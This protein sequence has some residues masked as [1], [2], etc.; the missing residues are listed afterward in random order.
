ML[1]LLF[2]LI[3]V[4]YIILC[5]CCRFCLKVYFIWYGYYY[6]FFLIICMK[7][8]FPS[9]LFQ[10]MC[11][12]SSEVIMIGMY[13]LWFCY[14]SSGCFVYFLYSFLPLVPFLVLWWVS[15]VECL[16]F[17]SFFFLRATAA[18]YGSSQAR[19]WIGAAVVGLCHSNASS[20]PHL[21]PVP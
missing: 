2:V 16:C 8:L 5:F 19:D 20:E 4:F 7:Y 15:L 6:I 18:A 12:F 17:F 11:V 1:Y 14:L 21:Q 3:P 10:F 9:P 13:L